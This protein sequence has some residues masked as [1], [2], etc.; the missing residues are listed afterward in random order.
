MGVAAAV[1]SFAEQHAHPDS[2]KTL[3]ERRE[4]GT[5][6]ASAGASGGVEQDTPAM[7][8]AV[9]S[10][11]ARQCPMETGRVPSAAIARLRLQRR[12]AMRD[13]AGMREAGRKPRER[14]GE[15]GMQMA[16]TV[17]KALAAG[18]TRPD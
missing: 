15:S 17:P 14:R 10:G 1:P 6:A 8:R 9:P 2:S 4:T 12:L 13:A 16:R 3:A 18:P 7:G 11:D 5:R